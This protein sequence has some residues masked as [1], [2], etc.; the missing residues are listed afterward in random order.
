MPRVV[1]AH[2][3]K[4]VD[5][6]T[7]AALLITDVVIGL[8]WLVGGD[9]RV[10][11][12]AYDAALEL[13]PIETYGGVLLLLTAGVFALR[14]WTDEATTLAWAALGAFWAW[15]SALTLIVSLESDGTDAY[16]PASAAVL[17]VVH[18]G[19]ALTRED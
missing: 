9:R 11:A 15:W 16:F 13:A 14:A 3:R 12:T 17:A 6:T 19:T 7:V 1:P 18:V 10:G 4:L 8:V 5:R 2:V